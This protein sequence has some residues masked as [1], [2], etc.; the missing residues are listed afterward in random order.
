MDRLP[1]QNPIYIDANQILESHFGNSV[2]AAD[3]CR[4]EEQRNGG[5]RSDLIQGPSKIGS[6]PL[7]SYDHISMLWG[8]IW[9]SQGLDRM[10][11]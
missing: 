1:K 11:G 3:A 7:R 5:P 6:Q 10:W 8:L 9:S 2:S 4:R